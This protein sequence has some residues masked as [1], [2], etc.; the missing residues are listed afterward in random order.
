MKSQEKAT[1]IIRE[2]I[3]SK[4]Y[5]ERKKSNNEIFEWYQESDVKNEIEVQ[6]EIWGVKVFSESGNLCAYPKTDSLFA[7]KKSDLSRT[8]GTSSEFF[9][10]CI[11]NLKAIDVLFGG[12]GEFKIKQNFI[13]LSDLIEYIDEYFTDVLKIEDVDIKNNYNYLAAYNVWNNLLYTEAQTSKTDE[14][15]GNKIGGKN[16]KVGFTQR[17][18]N[19]LCRDEIGLLRKDESTSSIKYYPTLKLQDFLRHNIL[20]IERFDQLMN[21]SK[22]EKVDG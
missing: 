20:D 13:I 5:L 15:A 17:A 14:K 16:T 11:I 2:I 1:T 22:E 8:L 7:Y 12:E 6:S 10:F 3:N 19:V 4:G 21:V 9:L 18:L